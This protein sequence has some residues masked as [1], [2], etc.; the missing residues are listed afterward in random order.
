M[1]R[2]KWNIIERM[3]KKKTKFEDKTKYPIV[4]VSFNRRKEPWD[5]LKGSV[6]TYDWRL[7]GRLTKRE[8]RDLKKDI[9][10]GEIEVKKT[11]YGKKI[12]TGFVSVDVNGKKAEIV[13]FAPFE[14]ISPG[15]K[16]P[17]KLKRQGNGAKVLHDTLEQ[18]KKEG[19]E[20]VV[21]KANGEESANFYKKFGFKEYYREKEGN[22]LFI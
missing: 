12:K 6:E 14:D 15:L 8:E 7:K 11:P 3:K 2:S 1:P 5:R 9:K 18:L 21:V 4:D 19:G 22:R 16:A 17:E 13:L 20:K 10:K